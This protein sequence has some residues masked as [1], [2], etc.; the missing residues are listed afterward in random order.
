[1][2]S[3][4]DAEHL[5]ATDKLKKERNIIEAYEDAVSLAGRRGMIQDQAL[6]NE[7]LAE[8]HFRQSQKKNKK[9]R[10]KRKSTDDDEEASIGNIDQAMYRFAEAKR[11]YKEWGADAVVEKV[12]R[13][14]NSLFL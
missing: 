13:R 10:D 2:I 1:M 11:L 3:M 14:C 5:I 8:F 4:L 12:E 6:A 7:R 9:K